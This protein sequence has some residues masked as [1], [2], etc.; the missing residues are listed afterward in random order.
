M[1]GCSS[2]SD[3]PYTEDVRQDSMYMIKRPLPATVAP[4]EFTPR[5]TMS[6]MQPKTDEPKSEEP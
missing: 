5:A 3:L 4:T 6:I 2:K 1:G